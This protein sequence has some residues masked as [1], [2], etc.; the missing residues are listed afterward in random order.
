MPILVGAFPCGTLHPQGCTGTSPKDLFRS[1]PLLFCRPHRGD[2]QRYPLVKMQDDG[3]YTR[4]GHRRCLTGD[5]PGTVLL[6]QKNR[7]T[8]DV[9]LPEVRAWVRRIQYWPYGSRNLPESSSH[10]GP[11]LYV[12]WQNLVNSWQIWKEKGGN[13]PISSS[14]LPGFCEK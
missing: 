11:G 9:P 1:D 2:W 3:N 7:T 4:S 14:S 8:T 13:S 10:I 5:L 12:L 6:R